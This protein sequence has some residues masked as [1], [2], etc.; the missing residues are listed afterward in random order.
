MRSSTGT[1][2]FASHQFG[3]TGMRPLDYAGAYTN[4]LVTIDPTRGSA[5]KFLENIINLVINGTVQLSLR[6]TIS[7][8]TSVLTDGGRNIEANSILSHTLDSGLELAGTSAALDHAWQPEAG[9]FRDNEVKSRLATPCGQVT[10]ISEATQ[11]FDDMSEAGAT[12]AILRQLGDR[13]GL[14]HHI[15]HSSRSSLNRIFSGPHT[16]TP[17]APDS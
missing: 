14:L 3:L 9:L 1:F 7:G 17:P 13:R 11:H 4:Q 2:T 5:P 8:G 10:Q 16:K 6:T 15:S 12:W